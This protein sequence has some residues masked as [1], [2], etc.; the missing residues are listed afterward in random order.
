LL[1]CG[2]S[3]IDFCATVTSAV[4]HITIVS[5]IQYYFFFACIG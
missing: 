5:Q 1:N 3:I 4:T 2:P